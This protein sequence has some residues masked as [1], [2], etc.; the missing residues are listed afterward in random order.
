MAMT[1]VEGTRA[2]TGGVDTHLDAHVAA[3]LDHLGGLSGGGELRD[4]PWREQ[5]AVY[6]TSIETPAGTS[7]NRILCLSMVTLAWAAC[8]RLTAGVTST[9]ALPAHST[10]PVARGDVAPANE[11]DSSPSP[12]REL[13]A[14]VS[15]SGD[16][17]MG[18]NAD[19]FA[20]DG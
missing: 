9:S 3:A 1:I 12:V 17:R 16:C 5:Q 8:D 7:T 11:P 19:A 14:L 2:V 20:T 10:L 18:G 6:P 15:A 4:L 13:R